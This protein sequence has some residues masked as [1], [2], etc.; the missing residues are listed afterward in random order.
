MLMLTMNVNQKR[1]YVTHSCKRYIFTVNLHYIPV[2]S[3]LSGN[4]NLIVCDKDILSRKC[5]HSGLIHL[6]QQLNTCE[7]AVFTKHITGCLRS[8]GK[9]DRPQQ[10]RLSGTCLSRQDIKP[11]IKIDVCLIDES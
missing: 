11:F 2:F 6:K 3:E 10:N 9:I 8:Q 7:I 4:Q 1:C 5:R